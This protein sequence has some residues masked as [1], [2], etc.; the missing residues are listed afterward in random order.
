[1]FETLSTKKVLDTFQVTLALR[2]F[3]L[4]IEIRLFLKYENYQYLIRLEI[5]AVT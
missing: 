2:T 5:T 4:L 1:M 3:C